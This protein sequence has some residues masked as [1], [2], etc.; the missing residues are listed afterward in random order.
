MRIPLGAPR[1]V[2][3]ILITV[4]IGAGLLLGSRLA[5]RVFPASRKQSEAPKHLLMSGEPA[6][7][8]LGQGKEREPGVFRLRNGAPEFTTSNVTGKRETLYDHL[9]HQGTTATKN[10]DAARLYCRA[11]SER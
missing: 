7:K 6:L 3:A 8:I 11:G 5:A 4:M 9:E 2:Y 1:I 10:Q